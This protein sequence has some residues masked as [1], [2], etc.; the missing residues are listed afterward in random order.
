MTRSDSVC[1]T[2]RPFFS[3]TLVSSFFFK[4]YLYVTQQLQKT[5]PSVAVDKVSSDELSIIEPYIRDLSHGEQE[6]QSKP[7]SNHIVGSSLVHNSAYLHGTG[8]A[9]YTCDIPTPSDGLY[10]IPVLST[11]PYAKILSIDKTKAEEVPGFKAFITHLDLPGCN[12]TGDVVND[13]E[14][15]PS[16][17]VYCVGTIIGLVVA[18][19]EMHAQQAAKLIDI[20]YEC[21][22]PLI[23]TIDQAVEQ[24][25]YLGREL[26]LQFG[27][28]E[29]GFQE[30]DHTLTG[31]FYIGGQEHFYLETNCCL[32]IPHE[33]GELEL[34]VSTQNATG[35]QEKVAAVLGK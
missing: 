5:Y 15:F 12:L 34:Y 7:I 4:F 6:F 32:A 30:S 14:V 26:A 16:S 28:V 33:R 1:D 20:K 9:K 18:D 35:V 31:E 10:S 29:Q 3:R 21:L 23:F 24:K 13:E 17:I 11:Q 8:E 25:S 27:N 22:K 2:R 19:T